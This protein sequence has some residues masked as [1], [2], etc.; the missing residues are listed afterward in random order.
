MVSYSGVDD[1]GKADPGNLKVMDVVPLRT[2]ELQLPLS[3]EDL[4]GRVRGL[5]KVDS[6][7]LVNYW[8]HKGDFVGK[9]SD[10][11]FLIKRFVRRI[12]VP[13]VLG[14]VEPRGDG[15][16]L[17]LWFI[18]PEATIFLV[19]AVLLLFPLIRRLGVGGVAFPLFFVAC[20]IAGCIHF[21]DE[22]ALFFRAA[23]IDGF[24]EGN[25]HPE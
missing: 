12:W 4:L 24:V 11:S 9:V 25:G 5:V 21:Q 8:K 18:A 20:H 13:L 16:R 3:R 23:G 2:C 19:G 15:C 22:I 10:G 17:T 14:R 6:L 7:I 1:A